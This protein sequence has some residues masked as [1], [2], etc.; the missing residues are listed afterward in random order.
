[1]RP[2]AVVIVGG[3]VIGDFLVKRGAGRL[4]DSLGAT[5]RPRAA[6]PAPDFIAVRVRCVSDTGSQVSTTLPSL[7]VGT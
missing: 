5:L 6:H 4:H 2:R 3:G 7:A 1:M